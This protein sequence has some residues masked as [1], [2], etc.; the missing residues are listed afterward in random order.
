M[1]IEKCVSLREGEREEEEEVVDVVKEV[2]KF[3]HHGI[4][5]AVNEEDSSRPPSAT[6]LP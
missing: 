6:A 2:R 5:N 1:G 4:A 3:I